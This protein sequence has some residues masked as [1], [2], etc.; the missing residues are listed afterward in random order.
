MVAEQVKQVPSA[1]KVLRGF[2][3]YPD[4]AIRQAC[5]ILCFWH[6][7]H[8]AALVREGTALVQDVSLGLG[9]A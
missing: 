8:R 7:S 4:A 1:W 5:D 2:I 3:A 6:G 9:K